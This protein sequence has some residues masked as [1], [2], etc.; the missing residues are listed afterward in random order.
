M[1]SGWMIRWYTGEGRRIAIVGDEY[2]DDGP[3]GLDQD[4]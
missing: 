1:I 4:H 2:G 3:K